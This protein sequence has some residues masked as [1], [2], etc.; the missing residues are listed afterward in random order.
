[1]NREAKKLLAVNCLY[2]IIPLLLM[3]V[4]LLFSG[5]EMEAYGRDTS[6]TWSAWRPGSSPCPRCCTS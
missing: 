5:V 4:P 1:M 2:A 3:L 6:C